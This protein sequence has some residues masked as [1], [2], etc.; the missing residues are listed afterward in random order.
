MVGKS[1]EL[2]KLT[3][4][5]LKLKTI[6]DF[7]FSFSAEQVDNQEQVYRADNEK[8]KPD[9]EFGENEDKKEWTVDKIR[10]WDQE[11]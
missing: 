6:L 3:K 9:L 11:V 7:K 2:A 10:S 5:K 1:L 4:R 8:S